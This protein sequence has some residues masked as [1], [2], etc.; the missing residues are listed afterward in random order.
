MCATIT[1]T[2][3]PSP[4]GSLPHRYAGYSW[5]LF[6]RNSL[7]SKPFIICVN[8]VAIKTGLNLLDKRSPARLPSAHTDEAWDRLSI[9]AG[10]SV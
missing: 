5:K 1:H 6:C 9:S 4:L 8:C 10:H 3:T 2:H 7:Q